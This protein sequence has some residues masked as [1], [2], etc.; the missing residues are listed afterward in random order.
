MRQLKRIGLGQ[1]GS[2]S[3]NGLSGLV[4]NQNSLDGRPGLNGILTK[5][6]PFQENQVL[7]AAEILLADRQPLPETRV[8]S[9][10]N[11]V[12]HSLLLLEK[13]ERTGFPVLFVFYG[14]GS[15]RFVLLVRAPTLP[16]CTV[17]R[18][19]ADL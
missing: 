14:Y 12:D 8:F 18:N 17:Q 7:F 10:L 2:K 13:V 19:P 11:A 5:A 6:E 3:Q 15:T 9:A 16:Y 1:S 4:G